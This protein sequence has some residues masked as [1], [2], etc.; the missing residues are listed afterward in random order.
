M[1]G[2]H[3]LRHEFIVQ[4]T[5]PVH[6]EE[7]CPLVIAGQGFVPSGSVLGSPLANGRWFAAMEYPM[8]FTR[9]KQKELGSWSPAP[10]VP[11]AFTAIDMPVAGLKGKTMA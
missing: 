4:A 2:T 7:F 5:K 3:Y 11:E 8:A 9:H 1:P 6:L 10:L